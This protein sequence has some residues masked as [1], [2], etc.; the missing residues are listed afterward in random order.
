MTPLLFKYLDPITEGLSEERKNQLIEAMTRRV[1][2]HGLIAPAIIFLES[3]K[4]LAKVGGYT[5][6]LFSAPVLGLFGINGYEL[7]G[8]FSDRQNLER[9][10]K[11][12]EEVAKK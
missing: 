4:P 10:I 11:R 1:V 2:E 7:V 12:L 8:F 6:I 9:L 5:L 3:V